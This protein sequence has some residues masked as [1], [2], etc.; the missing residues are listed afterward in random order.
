[1]LAVARERRNT[2]T[3]ATK[4][5]QEE[6]EKRKRG[7]NERKE[8]TGSNVVVNP[9]EVEG[10]K[11]DDKAERGA[12]G[13]SHEDPSGVKVEPQERQQR[14]SQSGHPQGHQRLA[15]QGSH[16]EVCDHA[17]DGDSRSQPVESVDQV[18][19]VHHSD[20]PEHREQRPAE[21]TKRQ[22]RSTYKVRPGFDVSYVDPVNKDFGFVLTALNSNMFN[23]QHRTNPQ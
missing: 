19:R 2:T 5:C 1:M 9:I 18:Q 14:T 7:E 20:D 8:P 15:T 17:H 3:D 13:I 21:Q 10:E 12:A 11:R 16:Q 4:N 22:D 6:I 23:P